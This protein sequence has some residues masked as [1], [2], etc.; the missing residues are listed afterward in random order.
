MASMGRRPGSCARSPQLVEM[1]CS[2]A[3]DLIKFVSI[4]GLSKTREH[5]QERWSPERSWW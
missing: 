1:L 3:F 4:L 2:F 5:G